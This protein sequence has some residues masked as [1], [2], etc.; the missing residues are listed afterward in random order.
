MGSSRAFL[1]QCSPG[2]RTSCAAAQS[3]NM[4]G[5]GARCNRAECALELGAAWS[6]TTRKASLQSG[7]AAAGSSFATRSNWARPAWRSRGCMSTLEQGQWPHLSAPSANTSCCYRGALAPAPAAMHAHVSAAPSACLLVLGWPCRITAASLLSSALQ[8]CTLR[9]LSCKIL[10]PAC[11]D[12]ERGRWQC[13]QRHPGCSSGRS[14]RSQRGRYHQSI[15]LDQ[16]GRSF[17]ETHRY[18]HSKPRGTGGLL[19][20]LDSF[21]MGPEPSHVLS[22]TNMYFELYP[23]TLSM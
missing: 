21:Q 17:A 5:A 14:I 12:Q 3:S 23:F 4:S 16:D 7:R 6:T 9:L 20:V 15:M 10:A 8:C 1:A 18:T 11:P 2:S 19:C 22:S 13:W